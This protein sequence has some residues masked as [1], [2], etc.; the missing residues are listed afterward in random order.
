MKSALFY[1]GLILWVV[2]AFVTVSVLVDL[3]ATI[4]AVREYSETHC[5]AASEALPPV[6]SHSL[7]QG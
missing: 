7:G 4:H 3:H 6:P 1:A 2:A 5:P